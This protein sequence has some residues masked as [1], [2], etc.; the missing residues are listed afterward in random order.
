MQVHILLQYTAGVNTLPPSL[1]SLPYFPPS[2]PP[3]LLQVFL[4]FLKELQDGLDADGLSEE[5]EIL[6]SSL[7]L[8]IRSDILGKHTHSPILAGSLL[9]KVGS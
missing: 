5:L 3:S 8:S 2:L 9:G 7:A 6:D 1:L 4:K